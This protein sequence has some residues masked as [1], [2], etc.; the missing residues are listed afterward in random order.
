[1]P[2]ETRLSHHRQKG[3]SLLELLVVVAILGILVALAIPGFTKAQVQFQRQ[4]VSRQMKIYLERARFDSV[5]RNAD[6]FNEMAKL[7][8]HSPTSFSS[9]LDMNHNGTLESS[10]IHLIL[11]P[12]S[13]GVK[14]VGGNLIFPITVTFDHRGQAKAMNGSNADITPTFIICENNCT[15]AS[16][17]PTNSNTLS[18]S[19][20]GTVA[21]VE[22]GQIFFDQTIPNV[23]SV[24]TEL[25]I[26]PMAQISH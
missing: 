17:N 7:I 14:I 24:G 19:P 1:M 6:T 9:N 20:T 8:I 10:E 13:S 15:F 11:I 18:I 26:D 2:S 23:T 3:F 12:A 5:K 16:A 4:N 21:L 22:A 25:N